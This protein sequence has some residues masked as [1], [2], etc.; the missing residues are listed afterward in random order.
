LGFSTYSMGV[1]WDSAV[2]VESAIDN[3]CRAAICVEGSGESLEEWTAML[4]QQKSIERVGW[5]C[6]R[7]DALSFLTDPHRVQTTVEEW[8]ISIGVQ[9]KGL[10]PLEEEE[11]MTISNRSDEE[12]QDDLMQGGESRS[13]HSDESV[14]VISSDEEDSLMHDDIVSLNDRKPAAAPVPVLVPST[15]PESDGLGSGERA[16]DYGNIADLDF[17][18]RPVF[19]RDEEFVD[20]STPPHAQA[21]TRKRTANIEDGTS[22]DLDEKQ[23]IFSESTRPTFLDD[24]LSA[25]STSV[26]QERDAP[27]LCRSR[28][29]KSS[30]RR[31]TLDKYSRDGRW[32][33]KRSEQQDDVTYDEFIAEVEP[34]PSAQA[35]IDA[36]SKEKD[37]N[38][39]VE[40]I[41]LCEDSSYEDE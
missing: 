25:S 2:C 26:D 33:N 13:R 30:K 14:V 23:R 21:A 9:P 6:H 36:D 8:L 35:I 5:K 38:I 3:G 27:S 29:S 41:D 32:Y 1:V 20:L 11:D 31:R 17:L 34:E 24:D 40:P 28:A 39:D 10:T 4:H 7:V 15:S 22:D 16:S 37:Q 12:G 19:E 18:Q